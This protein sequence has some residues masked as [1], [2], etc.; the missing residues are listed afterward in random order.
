MPH[1]IERVVTDV[2][3]LIPEVEVVQMEKYHAADD[4]GIWWF[5]L[6]EV[7]EDIQI[8]SSTGNCPF[9]V[10]HDGMTKSEEAIKCLT[11]EETTS[12]VTAFLQPRR[13]RAAN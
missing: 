2:R 11:V 6:P 1:D 5:R 9:L 4:D 13:K 3:K 8:E 12:A 10:E 7:K